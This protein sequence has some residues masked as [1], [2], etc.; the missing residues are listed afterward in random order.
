MQTGL[1][2]GW[3]GLAEAE[4]EAE[5]EVAAETPETAERFQIMPG[6]VL[7]PFDVECVEQ[8]VAV[9]EDS[10]VQPLPDT[11]RP[12]YARVDK[13]VARNTVGRSPVFGIGPAFRV[14]VG[15]HTVV[16]LPVCGE[17]EIFQEAYFKD[18]TRLGLRGI[19]H[20]ESGGVHVDSPGYGSGIVVVD[21]GRDIVLPGPVSQ[22]CVGRET[23][24]AGETVAC[25]HLNPVME[26]IQPG[27]HVLYVFHIVDLLVR[28]GH[29]GLV[30][31]VCIIGRGLYTAPGI[32]ETVAEL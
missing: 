22:G 14:E 1:T 28:V 27:N 6:P 29:Q 21:V 10:E 13:V 5:V 9:G 19:S 15:I 25:F 16:E 20:R 8:V 30:L 2:A 23:H 11:S 31:P 26:G 18:G 32:D 3:S 4:P 12:A 7:A 24:P 17:S